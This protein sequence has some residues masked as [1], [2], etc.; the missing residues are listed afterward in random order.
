MMQQ[1]HD[2]I[3]T[4]KD[5]CLVTYMCCLRTEVSLAILTTM[6]LQSQRTITTK[7]HQLASTLCLITTNYSTCRL[8]SVMLLPTSCLQMFAMIIVNAKDYYLDAR[9]NIPVWSLPADTIRAVLG[10]KDLDDFFE[11][12]R[13]EDYHTKMQTQNVTYNKGQLCVTY[14]LSSKVFNKLLTQIPRIYTMMFYAPDLAI[15][16]DVPSTEKAYSTTCCNLLAQSAASLR[17]CILTQSFV[18]RKR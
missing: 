14:D 18:G 5:F 1:T 2:I 13:S 12:K 17:Q 3:A 15:T 11:L 6:S 7:Q 16:L 10:R 9:D 8:V 4:L